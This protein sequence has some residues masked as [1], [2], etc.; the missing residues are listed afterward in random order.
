[1]LGKHVLASRYANT[2]KANPERPSLASSSSPAAQ[3]STEEKRCDL[4]REHG[5][6]WAHIQKAQ[7]ASVDNRPHTCTLAQD[8]RSFLAPGD[9]SQRK[10]LSLGSMERGIASM[11]A[12]DKA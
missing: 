6:H 10:F 8:S 1:M 7:H 2:S 11:S 9:P 3:L 4:L 5:T 12:V